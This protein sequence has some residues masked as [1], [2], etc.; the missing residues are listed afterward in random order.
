MANDQ[1]HRTCSSEDVLS[2]KARM[3]RCPEC[4]KLEY[5]TVEE[6]NSHGKCRS[7]SGACSICAAEQAA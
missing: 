2:G 7:K 4:G 3:V 5:W 1:L 6:F